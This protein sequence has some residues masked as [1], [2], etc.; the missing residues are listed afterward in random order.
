VSH[1]AFSSAVA[2]IGAAAALLTV[3]AGAIAGSGSSGGSGGSSSGGS[4]LAPAPTSGGSSPNAAASPANQVV[5]ATGA[6]MTLWT[7]A[8][9]MLR[10]RLRIGG[11]MSSSE[12]G[13]TV[14]IERMGRQTHW[15]WV[16]TAHATVAGD[17]TF[18]AVWHVNHIGRFELRAVLAGTAAAASDTS[19]APSVTITAFRPARAT[20]YGPGFWGKRTACGEKLQHSTLGV[21]NRTLPCGTQVALYYNGRTIT[22]PVIDRGP[23]GTGADWDLTEATAT[24]LGMKETET[25]GAVSLPPG[26]TAP[27]ASAGGTT[28]SGS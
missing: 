9:A 25:I 21:A 1:R 17:G 5:S 15:R 7:H 14:Q 18:G 22:V 20:Y 13:K 6:G 24:A 12:A 3:P 4:G 8:S 19:S 23:Y 2:V 26:S 10:G 27:P 11:Q 28:S 16:V